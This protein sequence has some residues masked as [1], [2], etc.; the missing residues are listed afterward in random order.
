MTDTDA[1]SA[2]RPAPSRPVS[3]RDPGVTDTD[4][5]PPSPRSAPPRP[6]PPRPVCAQPYMQLDANQNMYQDFV[7]CVHGVTHCV[8]NPLMQGLFQ[9]RPGPSFP[10]YLN[11]DSLER[12]RGTAWGCLPVASWFHGQNHSYHSAVRS[13]Q[14]P[15]YGTWADTYTYQLRIS[16]Q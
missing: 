7:G 16:S 5:V 11:N 1:A 15:I 6:A 3:V 14:D 13:E 9:A 10:W 8:M 12:V 4:A 2:C